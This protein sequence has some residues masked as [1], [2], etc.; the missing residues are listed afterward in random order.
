MHEGHPIYRV[1]TTGKWNLHSNPRASVSLGPS[2]RLPDTAAASPLLSDELTAELNR[3]REA[4]RTVIE[5]GEAVSKKLGELADTV[6]QTKEVA[7]QN[8]HL[9]Q[10]VNTTKQRLQT[11]EEELRKKQRAEGAS[12]PTET[13]EDQ[14]SD[15]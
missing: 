4:T 1:E 6:Q 2:A 15:W 5:G 3:Q 11:L 12:Q 14:K 10:E 7:K 9:Q 8:A 13:P